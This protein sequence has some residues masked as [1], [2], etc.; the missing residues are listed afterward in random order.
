MSS[1]VL[2]VAKVEVSGI[3]AWC[4]FSIEPSDAWSDCTVGDV[5]LDLLFIVLSCL[6]I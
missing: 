5:D 4:L 6:G 3:V 1:I 2:L